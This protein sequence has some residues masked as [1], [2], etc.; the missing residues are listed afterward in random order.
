MAKKIIA[1]DDGHGYDTPGKRTPDGYK[2]N[3][4]NESVKNFLIVELKRNGFDFVDCSPMTADNSLADRVKR[5]NDSQ[6]NIFISIH[7]NAFGSGW[8]SAEGIETYYIG[9][10]N[11][12]RLAALV[13]A[14]LIKGTIQVNRGIKTANFYVI[15][16]T[17]MPAIL[18]E[19]AFMT[20]KK[21]AA[22]LKTKA[23]QKEVAMEICIGVCRYF[24]KK[25]I[26]EGVGNVSEYTGVMKEAYDK[27]WI[28]KEG[29][30][31]D[32]NIT[33]EKLMYILKNFE[34]YMDE[35]TK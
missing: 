15:V 33:M 2:E 18:V 25:Y 11:G 26:A 13:Q 14:E 23:Y 4:F 1:I 21:E 3:L 10:S 5:A 29:Y 17:N 35:K 32:D 7:A 9:N 16:H 20:N 19:V 8:N 34:K 24:G 30:N 31:K 27:K 22:L 28:T 6:A 12:K